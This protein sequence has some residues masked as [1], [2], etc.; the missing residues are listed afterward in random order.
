MRWFLG[1]LGAAFVGATLGN[2]VR[3]MVVRQMT[4]PLEE[5]E[6]TIG[7]PL[8]TLALATGVGIRA[9]RRAACCSGFVISLALGSSL[10]ERLPI[11][12]GWHERARHLAADAAVHSPDEVEI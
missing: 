4:Q 9:G 6:L 11:V 2:V 7:A 8:T 1:V 5:R 12:G 10:D 3:Q